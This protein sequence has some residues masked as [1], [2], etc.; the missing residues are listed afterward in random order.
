MKT[1]R[2]RAPGGESTSFS[3][4]AWRRST[5][6]AT[7]YHIVCRLTGTEES[8]LRQYHGMTWLGLRGRFH[9]NYLHCGRGDC[10]KRDSFERN[11]ANELLLGHSW[12]YHLS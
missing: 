12:Q 10:N 3:E 7:G 8:N 5:A 1:A 4:T 11:R 2:V 6:S 9:A